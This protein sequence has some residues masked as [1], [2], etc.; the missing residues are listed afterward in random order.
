MKMNLKKTAVI[1][2]AAILISGSA[3]AM[4]PGG[5]DRGPMGPPPVERLQDQLDLSDS[6][7]EELRTLFTEQRESRRALRKERRAGREKMQQKLSEILT[8][9]Q[10]EDFKALRGCDRKQGRGYGGRGMQRNFW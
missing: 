6:Q 4:G 7:V 10:L 3:Y 8:P 9:T 1:T 5:C 2:A